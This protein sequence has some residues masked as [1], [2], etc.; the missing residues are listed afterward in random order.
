MGLQAAVALMAVAVLLRSAQ[1]T[2]LSG[3][4]DPAHRLP[5]RQ[6]RTLCLGQGQQQLPLRGDRQAALGAPGSRESPGD[7]RSRTAREVLDVIA[8]RQLHNQSRVRAS[9]RHV[10]RLVK[11][12]QVAVACVPAATAAG[13]FSSLSSNQSPWPA[14]QD[15]AL[16]AAL[17]PVPLLPAE[18]SA[19]ELLSGNASRHGTAAV[20][21]ALSTQLCTVPDVEGARGGCARASCVLS[22]RDS[23]APQVQGALMWLTTVSACSVPVPADHAARGTALQIRHAA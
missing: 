23:R 4:K 11:V 13:S 2:L 9:V 20:G 3:S 7:R 21:A 16:R 15:S 19:W 10:T 22:F 5:H 8:G 6:L 1:P 18:L 17:H 14:Y 12:L